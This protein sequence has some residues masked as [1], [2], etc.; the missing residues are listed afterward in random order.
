MPPRSRKR[1]GVSQ[2]SGF[3]K[4]RRGSNRVTFRRRSR[5]VSRRRYGRI[6]RRFKRK[7]RRRSRKSRP[8]TIKR[9]LEFKLAEPRSINYSF[10]QQHTVPNASDNLECI[11]FTTEKTNTSVTDRINTQTRPLGGLDDIISVADILWVNTP[12]NNTPASNSGWSSDINWGAMF[13]RGVDKYVLRNQSNDHMRITGYVC[14]C[15][16][17][18][19][20]NDGLLKNIYNFLGTGFAEN[21]FN[22]NEQTANNLATYNDTMTP[23]QSR[24]FCRTFKIHRTVRKFLQPGQSTTHKLRLP[25]QKRVPADY[26]M[27]TGA[28]TAWA[29]RLKRV[30]NVRGERFILWK[31]H[32][33]IGGITGQT[34]LEKNIGQTT[35]TIIMSTIRHYQVKH[36]PRPNASVVTFVPSGIVAGSA[37]IIID[38]DEKAGA[39]V[40]AS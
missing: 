26:T 25:W 12:A 10:G 7:L 20:F 27:N 34:T 31:L 18:I 6:K 36:F 1:K 15:R 29:D 21:G 37:S 2:R 11:Y 39:E 24:M 30:S 38:D 14:S 32:S 8:Q 3:R 23:F 16:K 33:S 4:R 35:P 19:Q 13:I 5:S 9:K 40:D 22:I 28:A 17:D